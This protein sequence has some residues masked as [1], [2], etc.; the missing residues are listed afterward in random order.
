MWKDQSDRGAEGIT[1]SPGYRYAGAS[2]QELFLKKTRSKQLFREIFRLGR[3]RGWKF[4]HSTLFLDFLAGNRSYSCT[5]WGNPTR[6]VL[7][8]QRPCY[9]L[10]EGHAPT[11]RA[12]M[13]ETDWGRYGP[14]RNPGCAHCMLHSGFEATAVRD[15]LAH[16]F[17]ALSVFLRGP[18]TSGPSAPDAGGDFSGFGAWAADGKELGPRDSG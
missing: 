10:A 2:R 4:N 17:K 12:L 16:P 14:G 18:A 3:G 15:T 9:L 11:Y 6:N 1:L 8:W 5:P 13:E 7:G